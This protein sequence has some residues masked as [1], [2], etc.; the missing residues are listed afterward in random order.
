[1]MKVTTPTPACQDQPGNIG[2][3]SLFLVVARAGWIAIAGLSVLLQVVA[4]P[5]R[6]AQLGNPPTPVQVGL[7]S[8]GLPLQVYVFYNLILDSCLVLGFCIAAALLFWR[9][10][11]EWFPLL[12]AFFL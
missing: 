8:L 10:S 7:L 6:Y 1:M 12:I 9:K 11:D 3:S 5:V 4:L 2:R